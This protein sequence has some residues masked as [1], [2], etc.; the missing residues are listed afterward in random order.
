MISKF[1]FDVWPPHTCTHG[2]ASHEHTKGN[3]RNKCRKRAPKWLHMLVGW[4]CAQNWNIPPW[5]KEEGAYSRTKWNLE[6]PREPVKGVVWTW[7][8]PKLLGRDCL[9]ELCTQSQGC[10]LS[11]H[12]MFL[13]MPISLVNHAPAITLSPRPLSVS[14]P[15][16]LTW[17]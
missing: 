4:L 6:R 10:N 13:V 3:N 11:C 14:G 16:N 12:P 15:K 8:L 7:P 9:A 5:D 2:H 1:D 17:L